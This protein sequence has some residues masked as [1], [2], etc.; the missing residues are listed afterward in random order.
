M[1]GM[2]NRDE[3]VPAPV[4]HATPLPA[5]SSCVPT[6]ELILSWIA[7][8]GGKP[9][10]ASQHAVANDTDRDALDDPLNQL[11]VAGLVRVAAWERG[12]GQGY[13]LTTDGEIALAA[14]QLL[15]DRQPETIAVVE[16]PP[17]NPNDTPSDEQ[18][19]PDTPPLIVVPF[20][21]SVNLLW[22]FVGLVMVLRGG[23]P[24]WTYLTEGNADVLHRLGAVTGL[25]LLHGEWW[26][27]LT[28]CFVHIGGAHLLLNV[29]ALV[30][31][32]PQAEIDWGRGRLMVIYL[33]SG[34]AGSCLTM[35]LKPEV[36]LAGA[37]GAIWGMMLSL[38]AWLALYRHTLPTDIAV[39]W[40]RRLIVVIVLNV[41]FSLMPIVSW[42][43]H[44][45]GAVGGFATALLLSSI[46]AGRGRGRVLSF[47]LLLGVAA[48]CILGLAASM[49]WGKHWAGYRQLVV[50][51]K[52]RAAL[53]AA[54]EKF[55]REV[56]PLLDQL[57]PT[58]VANPAHGIDFR[59]GPAERSAVIQ[60]NRPGPRRNGTRVAEARTKL[61]ELKGIADR[62][63]THLQGPPVGIELIDRHRDEA[64]AF[65]EARAR[66]V[67]LLLA[68]LDSPAIPDESAWTAWTEAGQ[69]ADAL[70]LQLTRR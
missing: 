47:A 36:T 18:R 5:G 20:L 56:A 68:M 15:L 34:L 57:K 22:F 19:L 55:N 7:R 1:P 3:V 69:S 24:V 59:L 33:L 9:W 53:L 6:P 60:L 58:M 65:A 38:V 67:A 27:L 48:S 16:E 61:T 52:G 21:L 64:K 50:D 54:E 37:S 29:F 46:H 43:A 14:G 17:P 40:T 4:D 28:A 13:L 42:Q 12:L 51:E 35:S 32:G 39:D 10:F 41:M 45:G 26:R 66:S 23:L 44:L 63:L 31:I 25:D 49:A 70:W 2:S 8:A 62:A 11:R 30:L